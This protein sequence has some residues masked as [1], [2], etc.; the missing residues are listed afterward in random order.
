[1][2]VRIIEWFRAI[3]KNF[4][5]GLGKIQNKKLEQKQIY[6]RKQIFSRFF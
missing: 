2:C 3:S 5:R 6:G 1:M 4:F